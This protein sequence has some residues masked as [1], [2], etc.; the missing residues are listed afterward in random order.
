MHRN[1]TTAASAD[2][3]NGTGMLEEQHRRRHYLLIGLFKANKSDFWW[4]ALYRLG[5]E[6][7]QLV[8][9]ILLAEIL[10]FLEDPTVPATRGFLSC[11]LLF[12]AACL[13]TLLENHYFIT[14]VRAG[15]RARAA[16]IHLVYT[17]SLRLT[18]ASTAE[19][20][21]GQIV[22]LMQMDAQKFYDSSWGLHMA[23]AAIL[24]IF[25]CV[26]LL[27]VYLGPA[28]LAGLL[29]MILLV[30]INGDLVKRQH[31]RL[32][33]S[34]NHSVRSD[35][36]LTFVLGLTRRSLAM[37]DTI[38][39]LLHTFACSGAGQWRRRGLMPE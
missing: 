35:T 27:F 38:L 9:P 17:K 11:T 20:S 1:M 25:G 3:L 24:Q 31:V 2:A 16:C 8:Q 15:I 23:W 18:A 7:A 6:L 39:L 12:C 13:K 10:R 34:T 22:N 37:L 21:T 32:F 28:M 36:L 29:T 33:T 14:C 5:Q 19:T 4:S 30:P 26:V